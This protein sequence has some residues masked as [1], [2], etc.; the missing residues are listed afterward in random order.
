VRRTQEDEIIRLKEQALAKTPTV[1]TPRGKSEDDPATVAEIQALS[2]V[3][4]T[5]RAETETLRR[6]KLDVS[7]RADPGCGH[8]TLKQTA[9]V[10]VQ[11]E[12]L[13]FAAKASGK[14]PT[15][16]LQ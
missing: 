8:A 10:E 14:T 15:S 12:E 5:L 2:K 3:I 11:M 6:Q 16:L 4:D 9:Q 13:A 1:V 7:Y